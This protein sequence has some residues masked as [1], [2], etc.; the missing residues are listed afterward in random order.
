MKVAV[1]LFGVHYIDNLEHWANWNVCI[2]YKNTFENNKEKLYNKIIPSYYSSTYYSDKLLNLIDDYKFKSIQLQHIDNK[3]EFNRNDNWKKRNKRFKETIKLI[4]D[5]N[6][7]YDY[8]ILTR[9]DIQLNDYILE[10]NVDFNKINV[11]CKAKSGDDYSLIDD[12]F[13]LLPYSELKGFYDTIS[14]IDETIWGHSYN[15]FINNF[16][17]LIDGSY[18]SHEIPTY[19]LFKIFK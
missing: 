13:Y 14:K 10:L 19:Q 9:Y 18:Y 6:I 11:V 7:I 15:R 3:V 5:D 8:V 4:L 17:Y 1:G 12:N 2:N 16:N